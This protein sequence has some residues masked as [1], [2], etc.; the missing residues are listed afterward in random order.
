MAI[1]V[2]T[3]LWLDCYGLEASQFTA[4]MVTQGDLR[5]ETDREKRDRYGRLLAYVWVGDRMLNA[6]LARGGYARVKPYPPNLRYQSLLEA[7]E[8]EARAAGRGLWAACR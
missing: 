7:A 1:Q 3:R 2:C 8:A 5:L 6:E 4:Q